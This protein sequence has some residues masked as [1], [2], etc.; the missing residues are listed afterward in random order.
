MAK[1]LTARKVEQTRANPQQAQ[2]DTGRRQAGAVPRRSAKQGE[3][4][5][6]FAIASRGRHGS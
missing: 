3:S 1:K 2:R 6:P 4:P 5:G